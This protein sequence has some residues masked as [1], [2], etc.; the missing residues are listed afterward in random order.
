MLRRFYSFFIRAFSI[1]STTELTNS[2]PT[3]AVNKSVHAGHIEEVHDVPFDVL[4]RPF[5]SQLDEAKVQSLM[6]TIKDGIVR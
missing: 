6:K 4:I 1:E 3:M 5:P 2:V